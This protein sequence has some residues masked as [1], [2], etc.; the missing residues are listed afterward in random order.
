MMYVQ[1]IF[2]GVS[3]ATNCVWK[4]ISCSIG[5]RMSSNAIHLFVHEGRY[6]IKEKLGLSSVKK[7]IPKLDADINSIMLDDNDSLISSD[8]DVTKLPTKEFVFTFSADEWYQIHP[9]EIFYKL[10]DKSRPMQ[11]S[12]LYYSFPKCNWT[13]IL[14][15]HFWEHTRLPCCLSFRRGKV[16]PNGNNY[17]VVVARC[18]ICGSNFKGIISDRPYENSR[19]LMHCIYSGNFNEKHKIK[20]KHRMLGPVIFKSAIALVN[21]GM[22]CETYREKE[23][24]RLMKMGDYEPAIL[25]TGNALRLQKSKQ[26]RANKRSDDTLT[27][28]TIMKGEDDFKGVIRDIGCDPFFV[29]YHSSEQI[30][31]YRSYC[32]NNTKPRLVIDAT[33]S[34]IKKFKKL[35]FENTNVI[36]LYECVVY[37]KIPGYSFTVTN[38]ISERHTNSAIANWLS[39]LSAISHVFTQYS[40]LQDYVRV[41]ADILTGRIASDLHWTPRCFIRI[42]VAHFIKIVCRKMFLWRNFQEEFNQILTL[43]EEE[44]EI[45]VILEEEYER[46][47]IGLDS[48]ENPFQSWAKSIYDE[49]QTFLE[50]GTGINPFYCPSLVPII[51]KCLKLFPLWSGIMIPIFGY[52]EEVASSATVESSFKKLKQ[53]TFKSIELPTNLEIFLENHVL[54]LK[55]ASIIRGQNSSTLLTIPEK[56]N[57]LSNNEIIE[58]ISPL[59]LTNTSFSQ[60]SSPE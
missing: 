39:L 45:R 11:N 35:G 54:S 43:V 59:H 16:T 30:Y 34:V 19:V 13:P 14:A 7:S 33:G 26:I 46:Q 38:M 52:G 21:E 49:S 2:L 50:E 36:Y 5:N 51:I 23:A 29:H 31:L 58:Q 32:H 57:N 17:A 47:N 20:R 44:D 42:D 4:E 27:A 22:A 25:P 3:V 28:L 60:T 9:R 53:L 56:N 8:S 41:C 48:F 10:N 40:L 18:S 15:E 6:G 55:G 12:K 37:D 1:L 24:T